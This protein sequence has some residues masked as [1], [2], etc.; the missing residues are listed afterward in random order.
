MIN[1]FEFDVFH[2]DMGVRVT[3]N[4]CSECLCNSGAF[5]FCE[6]IQCPF[7][8]TPTAVQ[9]CTEDGTTYEHGETFDSDCNICVCINGEVVCTHMI[10]PDDE[11]DDDDTQPSGVSMCHTLARRP[12][13]ARDLRTYPNLCAA[14]A[15]GFNQLEVAP[16]ACTRQVCAVYSSVSS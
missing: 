2:G 5:T 13:C 15:A 6:N 1:D 9:S 16:G 7:T 3:G 8:A 11:D 12:V 4:T 14:Q 10:C